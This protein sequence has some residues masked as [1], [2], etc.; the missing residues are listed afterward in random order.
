MGV[1]LVGATDGGS[2]PKPEIELA[3]ESRRGLAA[4]PGTNQGEK[5]A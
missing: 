5:P 3:P 4:F 2:I 1:L